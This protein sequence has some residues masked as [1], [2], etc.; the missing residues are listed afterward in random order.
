MNE[1]DLERLLEEARTSHEAEVRFFRTLLDAPIYAH[2]PLSDDHPMLRLIAFLHPDG[3]MAIPF[4]TS[5]GKAQA[6]S[7][8]AVRIVSTTGRELFACAPGA[9]FMLNP[10]DGGAVLFPEE[11]T[12]LLEAG[13]VSS[14][15]TARLQKG[16]LVQVMS[17]HPLPTWFV[18]WL[19]EACKSLGFITSGRL[20][21]I[22]PDPDATASTLLIAL[23]VVA[24]MEERAA[25]G[26]G[27]LLQQQDLASVNR[28]I[29]VTTFDPSLGVPAFWRA[30]EVICFHQM[31]T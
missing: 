21:E 5:L 16:L 17:P 28:P 22:R 24:G 27:V 14:V 13:F 31:G 7:G 23:G 1:A 11:V 30:A 26:L 3:F 12:A 20:V 29:D 10:N 2:A 18:P 4:F 15:E 19:R 9:T 8:D 6:A 25:R